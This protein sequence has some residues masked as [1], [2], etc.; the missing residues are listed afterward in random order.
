MRYTAKQLRA[1]EKAIGYPDAELKVSTNERGMGGYHSDT[2]FRLEATVDGQRRSVQIVVSDYSDVPFIH[3]GRDLVRK[4]QGYITD[5][6]F[7]KVF[8]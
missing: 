1:V 8:R 3:V 7:N 4:F 5:D 6:I 2:A